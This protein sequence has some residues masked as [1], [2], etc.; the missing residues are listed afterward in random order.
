M[1]ISFHSHL[2][3][4]I[5]IATKVCTWHDSCAVVACAK[6]LL[7]SDGQQ[8]IYS[9]AMFPSNLNCGKKSLVKRAPGPCLHVV[10]KL[11]FQDLICGPMI[12]RQLFNHGLLKDEWNWTKDRIWRSTYHDVISCPIMHIWEENEKE[13]RTIWTSWTQRYIC[14]V[15]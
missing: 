2:D 11:I 15:V 8:R 6:N 10:N 1:E 4:S 9:K 7:R 3:S 5:V 14:A 13:Q 12:P